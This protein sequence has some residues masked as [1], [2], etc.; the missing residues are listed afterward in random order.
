MPWCNT[1]KD[2]K[3]Y[4]DRTI[5]K[6]ERNGLFVYESSVTLQIYNES[7]LT[8]L[9]ESTARSS[10]TAK[11]ASC[12]LV[13]SNFDII[14]VGLMCVVQHKIVV[15]AQWQERYRY[16]AFIQH[17]Q[18]KDEPSE[19]THAIVRKCPYWS[20]KRFEVASDSLNAVRICN[21][22]L[23]GLWEGN[24]VE[25]ET[26]TETETEAGGWILFQCTNQHRSVAFVFGVA[27]S[28]ERILQVHKCWDVGQ[29][30]WVELVITRGY[31][32]RVPVGPIFSCCKR[33]EQ[34]FIMEK[35][36]MH[37]R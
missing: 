4:L 10:V 18:H 7:F 33:I 25:V 11:I 37:K 30:R 35:P 36:R 3:E 16:K 31:A 8:H 23:L 32:P 28:L 15:S 17:W 21:L 22:I 14:R 6:K 29:F 24:E 19:N 5:W 13:K 2:V 26:R 20:I 34:K 9:I 1:R 27:T 12:V